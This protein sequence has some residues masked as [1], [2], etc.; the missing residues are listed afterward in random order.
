M[1]GLKNPMVTLFYPSIKHFSDRS[2]YCTI[3][4]Q[5]GIIYGG[6]SF[7]ADK[8]TKEPESLIV[9]TNIFFVL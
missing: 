4:L 9:K 8:Y 7:Y 1:T 5:Q 3:L 6:T 2:K